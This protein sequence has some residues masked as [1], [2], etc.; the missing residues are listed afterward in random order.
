[1]FLS[2]SDGKKV[3]NC[4]TLPNFKSMAKKIY[5]RAKV[6]KN[7]RWYIDYTLFDPATGQET[8]HRKDFNLNS[9]EDLTLREKVAECLVQRIEAF[10]VPTAT[11]SKPEGPTLKEAIELAVAVKQR[12]PRLSSRRKYVTVAK[13][14]LAWIKAHK[15]EKMPVVEFTRKDA[16]GYWDFLTLGK[17][18]RGKTLNNYLDALRSLWT[19]M[20]EREMVK[21]NPWI[22]IKQAREEAKIRR[23]FTQEERI[24]VATH[25]METD[26]WLFRGILLQFYC[27]I[28]PVE[29]TRLKFRDFNFSTGT[30]TVQESDAKQ[31]RRVVKTIPRSV[32]P[33]FLDGRFEKYPA[34][35]FMFGRVVV[36]GVE[37]MEPSTVPVDVMRPYKRH[38]KL[39]KRLKDAGKLLDTTGLSWYSWKDTGISLHARKTGPVATKDQAGHRNLVMTSVY[40]HAEEVN[41]E[42]QALENDLLL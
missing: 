1:M 13:P 5:G 15:L 39:L 26:Y 25:A 27:Y 22:R 42:Y 8:R 35:Y 29:L 36:Q 11:K 2:A 30:V 6:I 33:Y 37:R 7:G 32:L 3:S 12:L 28:R 41:S 20:D 23:P 40:Y 38:A 17:E 21:E 19:E 14:L 24:C 9:I 18:Y 31:Y 4:Q 34:N 16:R 10:A